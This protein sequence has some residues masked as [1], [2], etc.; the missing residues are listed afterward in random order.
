MNIS[1]A[2]YS[3]K[4]VIGIDGNEANQQNRVGVGQFAYNVI[5]QLEKIDRNNS[6][7]IYLKDKPLSDLPKERSGWKYLVFGPSKLWT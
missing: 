6:Y 1:K 3:H 7:T 2:C 4:L 5:D